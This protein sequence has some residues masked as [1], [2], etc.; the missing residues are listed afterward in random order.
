MYTA[1]CTALLLTAKAHIQFSIYVT[2][3]NEYMSQQ[4]ALSIDREKTGGY[5]LQLMQTHA[6]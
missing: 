2:Y 4:P 6:C 5:I 3:I 1:L